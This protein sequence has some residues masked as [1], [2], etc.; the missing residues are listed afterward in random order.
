VQALNRAGKVVAAGEI[1][2][3]IVTRQEFLKASAPP[4]A[5]G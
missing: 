5:G 3:A 2:R 4:G 1:D